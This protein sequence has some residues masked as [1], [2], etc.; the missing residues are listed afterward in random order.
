MVRH[1]HSSVP[2]GDVGQPPGVHDGAVGVVAGGGGLQGGAVDG[3]GGRAGGSP[4]G[5]DAK[6]HKSAFDANSVSEESPLSIIFS[7]YEAI[8]PAMSYAHG[9]SIG[10]GVFAAG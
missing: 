7:A 9:S 6:A 10:I 8:L 1:R 4:R 3:R 5:T 2:F